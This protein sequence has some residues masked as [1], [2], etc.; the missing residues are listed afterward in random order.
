MIRLHPFHWRRA[1]LAL[2]CGSWWGATSFVLAQAVS[3]Y[4]VRVSAT[5]QTNPAQIIFA[6]PANALGYRLESTAALSPTNWL[7]VT[8]ALQTTNGLNTVLVDLTSSN[9]LFRLRNP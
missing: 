2:V 9:Q 3:D 5:V 1:R 4:A 6:R 8:N 7:S